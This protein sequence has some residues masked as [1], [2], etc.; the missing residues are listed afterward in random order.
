MSHLRSGRCGSGKRRGGS[1]TGRTA[2]CSS[3]RCGAP[4]QPGLH[5]WPPWHGNG[6]ARPTG[7]RELGK[8][9]VGPAGAQHERA[10]WPCLVASRSDPDG[11]GGGGSASRISRLVLRWALVRSGPHS[12]AWE[13][14]LSLSH[15]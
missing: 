5:R 12:R 13:R 8:V 10:A 6:H 9:G 14:Y 15:N 7:R 1:L 2:A 3:C 11:S 4:A